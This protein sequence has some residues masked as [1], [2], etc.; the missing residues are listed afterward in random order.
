MGWISYIEGVCLLVL[1]LLMLGLYE[2]ALVGFVAGAW[3][4][5]SEFT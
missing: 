5:V 4:G 1:G 3:I 2:V